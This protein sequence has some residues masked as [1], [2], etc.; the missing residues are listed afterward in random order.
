M[1]FQFVREKPSQVGIPVGSSGQLVGKH[2]AAV[3]HGI[4][5]DFASRPHH[6]IPQDRAGVDDRSGTEDGTLD[7]SARFHHRGRVDGRFQRELVV[8]AEVGLAIAEVQPD[9]LVEDDAVRVVGRLGGWERS[10]TG[11]P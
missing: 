3:Q 7:R 5:A 11:P 6:A 1:G 9:A 4:S 2:D 10:V 8:G